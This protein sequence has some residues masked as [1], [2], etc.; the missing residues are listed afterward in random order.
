MI[1]DIFGYVGTSFL[2]IRF[3]PV[4]IQMYK[5]RSVDMNVKFLLIEICA[6]VNLLV[7]SILIWSIP[8][9]ACNIISSLLM[10][11]ILIYKRKTIQNTWCKKIVDNIKVDT[12][13]KTGNANINSVKDQDGV[14]EIETFNKN[15]A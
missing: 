6:S 5:H 14:I 8:F 15:T 7:S 10:V 11:S 13:I 1:S 9:I 3:I 12:D 4:I 2:A